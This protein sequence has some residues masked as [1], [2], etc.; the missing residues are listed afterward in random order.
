MSA[1]FRVTVPPDETMRSTI[2][3]VTQAEVDARTALD[4]PTA[5]RLHAS[6]PLPAQR[7]LWV[8]KELVKRRLELDPAAAR[9]SARG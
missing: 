4:V 8:S 5:D 1:M 2:R 9:S 3:R 6:I 7:E